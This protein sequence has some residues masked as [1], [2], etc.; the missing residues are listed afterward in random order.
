[1]A[2]PHERKIRSWSYIQKNQHGP[3]LIPN[4]NTSVEDKQKKYFEKE[5]D[6]HL[7]KEGLFIKVYVLI[8]P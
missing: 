8:P 4:K 3:N 5:L 2:I 6:M 1:M 7:E